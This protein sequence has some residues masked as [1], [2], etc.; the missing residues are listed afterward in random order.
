MPRI[1]GKAIIKVDGEEYRTED[2]ATL[3]PGGQNRTGK[4]GGGKHHGYSEEDVPPSMECSIFHTKDTSLSALSNITGATVIF[5]TDS[6]ATYVLRDAFV[7]EPV[8]LNSKE[9]TCPMKMEAESFDD[10]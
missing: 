1:T 9:G 3:N 2:G 8:T 10:I 5:E 6:G 7:T 4:M